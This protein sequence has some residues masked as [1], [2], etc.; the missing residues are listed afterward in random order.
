MKKLDSDTFPR[1][2]IR[3]LFMVLHVFERSAEST[4]ENI[5]LRI[6]VDRKKQR[7]GTFLWS[8][9]RDTVAELI[10]LGLLEGVCQAKNTQQ[11]ESMKANRLELTEQVR[12]GDISRKHRASAYD[13]L[14]RQLVA[15]HPYLQRFISVMS[16]DTFPSCN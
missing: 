15:K 6:C 10:R 12:F 1:V 5:R 8:A 4:L 13:E 7:K 9:A 3:D 14:L 11:Y 2:T 16:N